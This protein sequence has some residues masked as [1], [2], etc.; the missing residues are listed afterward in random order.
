MGVSR[1]W[2]SQGEATG[3][4]RWAAI[5]IGT[6]VI[7]GFDEVANQTLNYEIVMDK[8]VE[9]SGPISAHLCFSCNEID[10]HIV[11][12]LGRVDAAGGY[13]LLCMGTISPARRRIDKA[14]ST[15]CEIAIDTGVRE[16]LT[17]GEPVAF[18][19]SLPP[20]PTRPRPGVKP[21]VPFVGPSR[22]PHSGACPRH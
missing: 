19:F 13:H 10:S 9:F 21:R 18:A 20:A 11:A 14:R 4:S 2:T 6:N 8:E 3:T 7:G 15:S 12:R 5:P 22:P 17:P 1:R 16:P